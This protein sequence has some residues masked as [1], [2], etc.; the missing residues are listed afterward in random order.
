MTNVTGLLVTQ[1]CSECQPPDGHHSH[2]LTHAVLSAGLKLF[3]LFISFD[4]IVSSLPT[5]SALKC[6]VTII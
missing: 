6:C 2:L 1:M 5:L 3:I 4:V